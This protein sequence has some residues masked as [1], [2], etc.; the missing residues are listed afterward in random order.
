MNKVDLSLIEKPPEKS[1]IEHLENLLKEAKSGELQ[2]IAY[3]CSYRGNF[4]NHGW[5]KIQNNRRM[6]GELEA[7]K[8]GLLGQTE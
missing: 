7:M 8:Y 1:L 5:T 4:V 6:I 2:E 3:V